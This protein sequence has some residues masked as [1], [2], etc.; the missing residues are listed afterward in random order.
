MQVTLKH[1]RK[2]NTQIYNSFLS[3]AVRV[4]GWDEIQTRVKLNKAMTQT[5]AFKNTVQG[6]DYWWSIVHQIENG[7]MSSD[8]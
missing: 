5:V 3:E 6:F 4:E 8:E 2:Y 1:L 7:K